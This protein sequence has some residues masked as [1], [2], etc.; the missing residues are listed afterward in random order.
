VPSSYPWSRLWVLLVRTWP[1]DFIIYSESST[2]ESS[3]S[4]NIAWCFHIS[5]YWDTQ[6]F[7]F[8]WCDFNMDA[9]ILKS[10]LTNQGTTVHLFPF[11]GSDMVFK[12]SASISQMVTL[13][14]PIRYRPGNVPTTISIRLGSLAID[15]WIWMRF[16]LPQISS[17][18]SIEKSMWD[19][20]GKWCAEVSQLRN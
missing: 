13:P 10:H 16:L 1:L 11:T 12:V 20:C 9:S 6:Q 19:G 4:S 7:R 3:I 17:S 8:W 5:H 15:I 18:R 14:T 2:S